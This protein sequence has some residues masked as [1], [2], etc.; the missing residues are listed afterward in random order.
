VEERVVFEDSEAVELLLFDLSVAPRGYPNIAS[1]VGGR[2]RGWAEWCKRERARE[3]VGSLR[4]ESE[5]E[6]E[7]A[8]SETGGITK[9]VRASS[10]AEERRVWGSLK[11]ERRGGE[12]CE[13]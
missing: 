6:R 7:R 12:R 3:R 5:F 11:S 8:G 1:E 2:D 4:R 13:R 9:R 10:A